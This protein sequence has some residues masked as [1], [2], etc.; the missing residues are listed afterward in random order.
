MGRL[1]VMF[2]PQHHDNKICT[3]DEAAECRM[4]IERR[5]NNI[6][7]QIDISRGDS[8]LWEKENK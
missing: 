7:F 6:G 3:G 1:E 8:I 2:R 4:C 5:M